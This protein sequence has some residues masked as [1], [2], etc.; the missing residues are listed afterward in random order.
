MNFQVCSKIPEG[1]RIKKDC[2]PKV[3]LLVEALRQIERQ[4]E[5]NLSD[6]FILHL[7][8][9]PPDTQFSCRGTLPPGMFTS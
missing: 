8:L 6:H 3:G 2:V 4:K 5:H 1:G 7:V 9:A